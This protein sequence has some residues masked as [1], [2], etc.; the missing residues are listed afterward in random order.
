MRT[1]ARGYVSRLSLALWFINLPLLSLEAA[2]F[3]MDSAVPAS[4]DG[5]SWATAWKNLSN[6]DWSA[7][8]PGDTI[9][10]SGGGRSK[11]YRGTLVIG[12][13]GT[14]GNP[15]KITRGIDAGHDGT[16]IL[17]GQNGVSNWY[18]VNN[19]WNS[20]PRN[21]VIVSRLRIQNYASAGLHARRVTA[22]VIYEDNEVVTGTVNSDSPRGIDIRDTT[23]MTVRG[24]AVTNSGNTP[25]QTDGLYSQGNSDFLYENNYIDITNTNDSGH[26]DAFQSHL[27]ANGIVRN[28]VLKS[29]TAGGNNHV[30]WMH[31]VQTGATIQFYNNL[32]WARGAQA[33]VSYWRETSG[34]P[35]GTI[36][37]WNNTIKGGYRALNFERVI[38]VEI[39]N[40]VISPASGG[41]GVY[42]DLSDPPEAN[43]THNLVWA[44]NATVARTTAGNRTWSAWLADGYNANGLYADPQFDGADDLALEADSPA[45]DAGMKITSV[46]TDINGASRPQ[47]AAYDIGA[48]E[49]ELI[50]AGHEP[51]AHPARPQCRRHID[52]AD[53]PVVVS[54]CR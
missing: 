9:Y 16:P 44:P 10:I 6:I 8:Q 52:I 37:I 49:S 26:S 43:V 14:A 11:T 4:G 27:D 35:N 48:F 45:I 25:G 15:I 30:A 12:A 3:Y 54:F 18:G 17:E 29:P 51:A 28:N 41:H 21:H 38:N 2:S 22:G 33:N 24:N 20:M 50:E 5:S 13:A 7:I 40:N 46:A 47:G 42:S 39:R 34:S 32:C 31:A 23:G 19:G 36:K 1:L 53:R